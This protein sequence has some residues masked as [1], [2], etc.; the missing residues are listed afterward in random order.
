LPGSTLAAALVKIKPKKAA[1]KVVRSADPPV[2]DLP[3]VAAPA[4]VTAPVVAK[5]V[6]EDGCVETISNT[7]ILLTVISRHEA[8]NL[9]AI[10]ARFGPSETSASLDSLKARLDQKAAIPKLDPSKTESKPK[11]ETESALDTMFARQPAAKGTLPQSA[12]PSSPPIPRKQISTYS[13]TL[14]LRTNLLRY[15]HLVFEFAVS[16]SAAKGTLP[17]PAFLSPPPT[18]RKRILTYL[19]PL[20]PR[21]NLRRCLLCLLF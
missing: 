12:F 21:T 4:N 19:S 16:Q 11:D 14:P 17:Q 6:A 5:P 7:L 13:P 20:P 2:Q 1:V 9:L 18:P 8:P 15:L 10:A 3:T